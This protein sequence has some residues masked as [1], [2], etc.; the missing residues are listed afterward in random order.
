MA[1]PLPYPNNDPCAPPGH[2]EKW[3]GEAYD[4]LPPLRE[5]SG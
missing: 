3:I 2:P 1:K 4:Q 5:V